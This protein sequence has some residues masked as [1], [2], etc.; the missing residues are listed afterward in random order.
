MPTPFHLELVTPERILFSGSAEEV[1]MRT[2]EGE[3]AFLAHHED[4]I[5]A[6]DITVLV[7]RAPGQGGQAPE[8]GAELRAAVHGGFVHVT[9]DGVTIL[10]SVAE[11]ASEVNVERARQALTRGEERLSSE[12][13]TALHL[14]GESDDA[15]AIHPRG[16]QLA[17]L[18]ADSPEAT[19]ARARARLSAAG[20]SLSS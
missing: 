14:G 17:L 9:D 10:A 19:I 1:T 13:P 3:I 16:A 6:L 7:I 20:A 5:G 2:D 11:L 15:Q 8:E 12:G 18:A 4:F